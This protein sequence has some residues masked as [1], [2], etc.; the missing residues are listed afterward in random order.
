MEDRRVAHTKLATKMIIDV[1]IER[2]SSIV[3][4]VFSSPPTS[5]CDTI[6]DNFVNLLMLPSLL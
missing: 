6:V 3:V 4:V 1:E 2:T 5:F